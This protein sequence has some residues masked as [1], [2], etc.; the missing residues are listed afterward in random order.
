MSNGVARRDGRSSARLGC[1]PPRG[2]L[3]I[4][5]PLGDL[6]HLLREDARADAVQ[7]LAEDRDL[8]A[9]LS[10][11]LK[12]GIPDLE[13]SLQQLHTLGADRRAARDPDSDNLAG[14]HPDGRAVPARWESRARRWRRSNDCRCPAH[15]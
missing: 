12:R 5:R 15:A 10:S 14:Q 7:E 1:E 4:A 9:A 11:A 8:F 13:R 2:A 6:R 3:Q